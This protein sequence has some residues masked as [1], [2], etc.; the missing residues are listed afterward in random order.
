[1]TFV[2]KLKVRMWY[3]VQPYQAGVAEIIQ[4]DNVGEG[5]LTS[6]REVVGFSTDALRLVMQ[7]QLTQR[8]ERSLI[9]TG[10]RR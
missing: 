3:Q 5:V 6:I 10:R 9:R 2:S 1:M 4:R 7:V 8:L